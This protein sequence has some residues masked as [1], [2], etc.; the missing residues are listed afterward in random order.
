MN[1]YLSKAASGFRVGSFTALYELLEIP[2]HHDVYSAATL[3]FP[4]LKL[5]SIPQRNTQVRYLPG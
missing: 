1:G 5:H 4:R 2:E 3:G